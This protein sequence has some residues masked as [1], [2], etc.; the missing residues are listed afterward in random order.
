VDDDAV[1]RCRRRGAAWGE[2]VEGVKTVDHLD[3]VT[4]VDQLLGEGFN[5][6][7]VAAEMVGRVEGGDH[8]EAQVAS[9]MNQ[10]RK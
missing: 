10:S 5:H 9:G 6:R 4:G 2:E 8:A 1:A 7:G 3:V